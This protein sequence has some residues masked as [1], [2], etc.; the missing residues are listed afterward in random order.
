MANCYRLIDRTTIQRACEDIWAVYS[1]KRDQ[2]GTPDPFIPVLLPEFGATQSNNASQGISA[3]N[4]LSMSLSTERGSSF[5]A[6][7]TTTRFTTAATTIYELEM[8]GW[9]EFLQTHK[10]ILNDR[11]VA[12]YVNTI[13]GTRFPTDAYAR[14]L[15]VD[16]QLQKISQMKQRSDCASLSVPSKLEITDPSLS[17]FTFEVHF[18]NTHRGARF[19]RINLVPCLHGP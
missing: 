5:S 14:A 2:Q 8:K 4:S 17:H 6:P 11:A 7:V 13:E 10:D 16:A 12:Q 3:G 1:H 9:A 15:M 19:P 18:E